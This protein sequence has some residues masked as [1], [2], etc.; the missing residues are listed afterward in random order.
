MPRGKKMKE[1]Q[2]REAAE[3]LAAGVAR[4]EVAEILGVTKR[5]IERLCADP[6]FL[7]DI[8][9]ARRRGELAGFHAAKKMAQRHHVPEPT[10]PDEVRAMRAEMEAARAA[11]IARQAARVPTSDA[12][13]LAWVLAHRPTNEVEYLDFRDA[14]RGVVSDH[15]RR[16]YARQL[17][18]PQVRIIGIPSIAENA[19]WFG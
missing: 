18:T 4:R 5:S 19:G 6:V 9:R 11:I 12:A 3:K 13:I 8:E 7:Q 14:E 15:A 10:H 1:A 2:R 17:R 16:R